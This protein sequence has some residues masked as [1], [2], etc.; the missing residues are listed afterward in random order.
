MIAGFRRHDMLDHIGTFKNLMV[1]F[2]CEKLAREIT[3]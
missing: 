2:A 3:P 1:W